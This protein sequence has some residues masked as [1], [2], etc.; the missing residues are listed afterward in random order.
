GIFLAGWYL[1]HGP[2]EYDMLNVRS[3]SPEVASIAHALTERIDPVIG[4]QGQEGVAIMVDEVRQVLPLKAA[5]EARRDAAAAGHEPFDRVATIFDLL[6]ERQPDKTS[7]LNDVLDRLD[8]PHT[9]HF[10]N[11]TD[12]AEVERELPKE[13]LRAVGIEDLP[14]QVVRAF[15]ERD[16]TRGRLV[17]IVPRSDRSVSDAHYLI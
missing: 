4:R 2:M 14:E 10:I 6:P 3:E 13:K 9:H 11:E 15:T 17:Y 7:L 8:R 1:R 16:G 5:L 12:W